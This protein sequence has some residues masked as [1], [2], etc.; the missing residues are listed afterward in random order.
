MVFYSLF[1]L[2][3]QFESLDASN[4]FLLPL[5]GR[6]HFTCFLMHFVLIIS[7]LHDTSGSAKF[8]NIGFNFLEEPAEMEPLFHSIALQQYII[9]CSQV[10]FYD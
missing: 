5:Y 9:L 6:Y 3:C 10:F 8:S 1:P 4:S 2:G 7:G